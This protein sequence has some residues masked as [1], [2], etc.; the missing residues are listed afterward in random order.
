LK[1]RYGINME[2]IF[3]DWTSM[4]FE[5]PPK[6]VIRMGYSRDKRPDRPQVTVGLSIDKE[7][8]MPVGLTIMPGNTV[9]VT[10]FRETFEQIRPLLPKDAMII[11]DNGAY[12]KENAEILDQNGLGF[13]T[14]LQMNGSDLKHSLKDI[15]KW[16]RIDDDLSYFMIDGSLKRKRFIFRSEKLRAEKLERYV[17]KA[18]RDYDKMVEIKAA[19]DRGKQP[20]KKYRVGNCFV[21]TK[22]NYKFLME[23]MS[24]EDAINE[25]VRRM[26][27]GNE[28]FFMLLTNRPLTASETLH[29]YRSRNAAENAF[30]DLKHGINWRPARCTSEDAVNGRILISFLALFCISMLRFLYPEFKTKT[31]ESVIEE[32]SSFS[33][34]VGMENDGKKRRIWSNFTVVIMRIIGRERP[35]LAPKVPQQAVLGAFG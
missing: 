10:H 26:T 31:A 29:M 17:R 23:G 2:I 6:D 20:R 25:A 7:S 5:A 16:T 8:G 35:V 4:Y 11:F 3:I 18:D 15:S 34:T 28:G 12:S 19:V 9:D 30:R 24:R 27:T 1:E 21:D 32:L 13:I 22:L 14:R 33:L